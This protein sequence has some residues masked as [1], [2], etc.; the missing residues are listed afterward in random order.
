[1]KLNGGTDKNCWLHRRRTQDTNLNNLT[2]VYCINQHLIFF[3]LVSFKR[4]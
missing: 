4:G 3:N 2:E 1:M